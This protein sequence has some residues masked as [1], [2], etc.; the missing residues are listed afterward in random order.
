LAA[1]AFKSSNCLAFTQLDPQ[2]KN[3]W[4]AARFCNSVSLLAEGHRG[5]LHHRG[6]AHLLGHR[7]ERLGDVVQYVLGQR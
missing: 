1:A 7:V 4:S 6:L 2:R 5:T 3:P